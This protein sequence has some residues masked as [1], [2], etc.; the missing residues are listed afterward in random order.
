MAGRIVLEIPGELNPKTVELGNGETL[1]VGRDPSLAGVN[2]ASAH[3]V[4]VSSP[5]VSK[6][7][8]AIRHAEDGYSL[9]DERSRN[10]TWV[11]LPPGDPVVV[12]TQ[13]AFIVRLGSGARA[14][15]VEDRPADAVWTGR[16]D[17][18]TG[19]ARAISDWFS[20]Q[21][22][23]ARVATLPRSESAERDLYGRIPLANGQDVSVVPLRTMDHRWERMAGILWSY[24]SDQNAIFTTEEHAR[25]EGMVLAS[26]A[27]RRVHRTVVDAAQRGVR[28]LLVGP[29]GAGKDGL[30]RVY[31]RNSGRPGAFVSRNCSMFSREFLRTELFG[32][33][34]GA[35]TGATRTTVGAVERAHG[36]TL[37]LDE[38]G[39]LPPEVQ[40][41][42]LTFLDNGEYERFG[43]SGQ[44][45]KA[46]VLIVSATNRDLRNAV[47]SHGFR[48]DL[49]YRIAGQV[50]E[51]PP[52]R[53][54]PDDVEAYLRLPRPGGGLSVYDAATPAA[55]QLLLDH[56]WPGN[57]RELR[58]FV[59]RMPTT[60]RPESIDTDSVTSLLRAGSSAQPTPPPLAQKRG[61][62]PPPTDL[63]RI[64]GIAA[65]AFR[66]DAGHEVSGWDDVK[67]YVESYLKPLIFAA[68]SG[69]AQ[70]VGADAD[71]A[72]LAHLIDADRGTVR[73]HLAR[74]LERFASLPPD[75][76]ER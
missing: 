58:S 16:S 50:V 36:G 73:K 51:V 22:V 37:F 66:A 3:V 47:A 56:A 5:S 76:D 30:A 4:Q 48:E 24:A 43:A 11:R 46:D 38:I 64:A 55:R 53:E 72:S 59:D 40:A 17:F 10:G 39:D 2:P 60:S 35:Y 15:A 54:R 69:V 23:P 70:G 68:L 32:A 25:G 65:E 74:F 26:A 57:F 45:R 1:V 8:V 19:V 13:Q 21:G 63:A 27:I 6:T 67:Q 28:L 9:V 49:W 62:M 7:H 14:E 20:E 44:P 52:L 75:G 71:I 34:K 12:R 31:H 29:S 41:M 61:P 33:E 42:L 18:H